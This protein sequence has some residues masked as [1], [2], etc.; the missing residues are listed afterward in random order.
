MKAYFKLQIQLINRTL[1]EMGSKPIFAYPILTFVFYGVSLLMFVKLEHA[2]YL[3]G[4]LAL[5]IVLQ[6]NEYRRN[7]FIKSI[8]PVREYF[9]IRMLENSIVCLPFVAFLFYK[10]IIIL[11]L[12]LLTV[13][14]ILAF[15]SFKSINNITI[16]TPFG[17]KPFE[18][19]MGFRKT[20]YIFPLAYYLTVQ[21]V[22]SGNINL[23][24][25]AFLLIAL[26]VLT[27][28]SKPEDQYYI[29]SY[30]VSAK[31]FILGKIKTGFLLFTLLSLPSTVPLIL[32][33]PNELDT[34][35]I[36][37]LISYVYIITIIL[38]KYSAYPNK[39][40]ATEGMFI[41]MSVMFIPILVVIIPLLYIKSIKQLKPILE[42]DKD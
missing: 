21:S 8:F 35:I 27:Y 38:A 9:K 12:V 18:F 40:N 42:H 2:E 7:E 39:V 11:P 14:I 36:F 1:V 10:Q 5:G 16:P 19:P 33:F 28:Y 26:V 17:K 23:G 13:S 4:I 3:Y 37:V 29:W 25:A 6:L 15:F 32:F 41:G 24:I 20:F 34:M 30:T 22:L 31:T